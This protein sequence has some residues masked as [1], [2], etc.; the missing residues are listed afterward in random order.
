MKN[1][2]IQKTIWE[3]E[4]VIIRLLARLEATKALKENPED[5]LINQAFDVAE[6][7][8][9][10]LPAYNINCSAVHDGSPCP[11]CTEEDN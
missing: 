11:L 5:E 8:K 7:L 6:R 10:L 1:L 9:N 2:D 3:A 4:V